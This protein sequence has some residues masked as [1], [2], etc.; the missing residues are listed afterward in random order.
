MPT[1]FSGFLQRCVGRSQLLGDQ[2]W[3][4]RPPPVWL[5]TELSRDGLIRLLF[6][7]RHGGPFRGRPI[8]SDVITPEPRSRNNQMMVLE[9]LWYQTI[10]RAVRTFSA[11][12]EER[13]IEGGIHAW[14]WRGPG[15]RSSDGMHAPFC[16]RGAGR[17]KPP[18]RRAPHMQDRERVEEAPSASTLNPNGLGSTA[19]FKNTAWSTRQ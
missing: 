4:W 5:Y 16:T 12:L 18:R 1:R 19:T 10:R 13:A 3:E 9:I 15:Q 14:P 2:R 11:L 8:G 6:P 17:L 7:L